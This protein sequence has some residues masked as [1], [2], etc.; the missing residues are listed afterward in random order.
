MPSSTQT[1]TTLPPAPWSDIFDFSQIDPALG[2]E[3]IELSLT[4]S[5][6]SL[7]SVTSLEGGEFESTDTGTVT[8]RRPD[9]SAWLTVSPAASV[10][11]DV[12]ASS[13]APMLLAAGDTS[14]SSVSYVPG[15][16]PSADAALLVGNGDG[17]PGVDASARVS[18][19]GPG[20]M[21][22]DFTTFMG[23]SASLVAETQAGPGTGSSGRTTP[24]SL[25]SVE[26]EAST[27]SRVPPHRSRRPPRF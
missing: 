13:G 26:V 8:L 20:N 17:E 11:A 2:I 18:A 1:S 9:G 12:P 15:Q 21:T 3:A 19:S 7:V 14:S 23:A 10:L 27:R 24:I 4:G 25:R 22:A 5:V 6:Y 16:A